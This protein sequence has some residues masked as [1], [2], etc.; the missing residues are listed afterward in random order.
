[1]AIKAVIFDLYG[2][3]VQIRNRRWPYHGLLVGQ[4]A[5]SRIQILTTKT[6]KLETLC[7]RLGL[8]RSPE[9]LAEVRRNIALEIAS[10]VLY[11]EVP[12]MLRWLR[13]EGFRLGLI[14]NLATPYKQPFLGLG[15]HELFDA[16]LF[17]CDEGLAKPHARIYKRAAGRLKIPAG[18][19]LMVGDSPTSDVAGPKEAGFQAILLDR[20]NIHPDRDRIS[21]LYGLRNM[22]SERS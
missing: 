17:S 15:L 22:L 10:V 14:S 18:E 4:P 7:R 20:R 8:D 2:T 11:P 1:M 13:Q 5:F 6:G 16:C 3:L 19:I 9:S 12:E 21:N